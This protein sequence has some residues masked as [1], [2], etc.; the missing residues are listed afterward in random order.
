[1]NYA[2]EAALLKELAETFDMD[3]DEVRRLAIIFMIFEIDPLKNHGSLY[4]FGPKTKLNGFGFL[5]QVPP[6]DSICDLRIAWKLASE[7]NETAKLFIRELRGKDR[8]DAEDIR[9]WL[10]VL[11]N[12]YAW[13]L[14]WSLRHPMRE[15]RDGFKVEA[16]VYEKLRGRVEQRAKLECRQ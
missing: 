15:G 5:H 16:G 1:M 10:V 4:V 3:V 12:Q 11:G 7:N 8:L 13:A 9:M 6:E 2:R 14:F